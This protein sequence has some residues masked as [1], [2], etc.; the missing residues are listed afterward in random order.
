MRMNDQCNG[1][2]LFRF[3]AKWCLESSFEEKVKRNWA[4]FLGSIPDKL[5]KMGQQLQQWC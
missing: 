5:D 2:R 4:I 3:E 1:A